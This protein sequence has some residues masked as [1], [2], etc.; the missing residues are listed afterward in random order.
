MNHDERIAIL[1]ERG[2]RD[3]ESLT[4]EEI[5]E[6]CTACL[7]D[8]QGSDFMSGEVQSEN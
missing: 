6:L 3:P 4:D 5:R 1:A 8:S 2:Q 7:C